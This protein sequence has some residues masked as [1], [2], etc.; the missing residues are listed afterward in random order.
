[1]FRND[2]MDTQ[3][4]GLMGGIY[5]ARRWD[6][7]RCHDI[8]T[9]FH[10]DWFRHSE[11]D[12]RGGIHRHTHRQYS[13]LISLLFFFQNKESRIA[14]SSGKNSSSTFLRYDTDRVENEA[15]EILLC[16]GNV[17]TELLPGN[18]RGGVHRPTDTRVSQSFCCCMYSLPWER[19]YRAVA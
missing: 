16:H 3:T 9:K 1:L 2:R 11:V 6:G 15:C 10:T 13:D 18:D 17:F 19:I 12:L 5:E 14:R 8:V 4:H 7:F